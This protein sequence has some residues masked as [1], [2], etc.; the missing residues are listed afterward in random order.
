MIKSHVL[1]RLSYGLTCRVNNIEILSF[2][3]RRPFLTYSLRPA[4]DPRRVYRD[5]VRGFE[6][7]DQIAASQA[8]V[9]SMLRAQALQVA[10]ISG[11]A[12]TLRP[13]PGR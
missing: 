5:A 4:I 9:P 6:I 7:S 12:D 10:A 13:A 3:S 2:S 1:Y 11:K 8:M